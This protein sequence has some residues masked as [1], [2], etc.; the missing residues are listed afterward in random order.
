[1]AYPRTEPGEVHLSATAALDA[2]LDPIDRARRAILAV[3]LR[4]PPLAAILRTRARRIEARAAS[5]I[6]LALGLTIACP[7]LMLAVG[8]IAFGVPH[9]AAEVRY[10]VIRRGLPRRWIIAAAIFCAAISAV[11]LIE[12]ATSAPAIC[13]RVEIGLAVI[14]AIGAGIAAA[15]AHRAW[16]RFALVAAILAAF[17]AVA[18]RHPL[19]TRLVFIHAHNFG[20]LLLWVILFRRSA[21]LPRIALGL[22]AA[23]LALILSGATVGWTA[24]IGGMSTLGVDVNAVAAWLTPESL[25]GIA[26]PLALVHAFSDSVHYAAWL[27]LIPEEE[28]RAEGSLTFKMTARSLIADL[29]APG[30]IAVLTAMAVVIAASLVNLA[31]TRRIYFSVA[32]FHGYL[33]VI[34]LVFFAVRGGNLREELVR[35][36]SDPP[37]RGCT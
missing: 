5:A 20:A 4:S 13:S 2:L 15:R 9:V 32:G 12:Q 25:L 21:R 33:E 35:T 19:A 17:T 18:A 36:R 7:A 27:G 23:S 26:V 10:L 16:R 22:L 6:L 24:R 29:G 8:P 3:A 37:T 31:E 28:A 34:A 1:M 30:I 14:G 11:R